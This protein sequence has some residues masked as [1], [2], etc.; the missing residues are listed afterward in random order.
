MAPAVFNPAHPHAYRPALCIDTPT[1][2]TPYQQL[3]ASHWPQLVP[4][5]VAFK[6]A[7]FDGQAGSTAQFTVTTGVVNANIVTLTLDTSNAS[8]GIVAALAED[9]IVN[10][11]TPAGFLTGAASW[12]NWQTITL[13]SNL[14]I[15]ADTINAGTYTLVVDSVNNWRAGR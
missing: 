12:T 1:A 5:L 2:G 6:S 8:K 10:N 7:V 9:A 4:H 14:T 15:G 3:L 11:T 13:P